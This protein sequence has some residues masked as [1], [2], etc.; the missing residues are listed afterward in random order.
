MAV[1]K[2]VFKGDKSWQVGLNYK[3]RRS[4]TETCN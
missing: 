3:E 2:Y 1:K 4:V